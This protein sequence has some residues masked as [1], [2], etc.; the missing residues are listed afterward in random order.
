MNF[1]KIDKIL[2]NESKFRAKQVRQLI[3]RDLIDDWDQATTLPIALRE[4]LKAEVPLEIKAEECSP[5]IM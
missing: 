1:D 4:K 5:T 3:W 2:A